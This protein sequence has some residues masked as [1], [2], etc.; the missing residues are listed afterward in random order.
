MSTATFSYGFTACTVQQ[1]VV[2]ASTRTEEKQ[3]PSPFQINASLLSS[4]DRLHTAVT[5]P[6]RRAP[7]ANMNGTASISKGCTAGS[8]VSQEHRQRWDVGTKTLESYS[9]RGA[10]NTGGSAARW[11]GS[12][13]EKVPVGVRPHVSPTANRNL[14]TPLG[15]HRSQICCGARYIPHTANK[16]GPMQRW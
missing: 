10:K 4:S 8:S 11:A 16:E 3:T 14:S 13:F 9:S 5:H 7:Y 15:Q 1:V 6:A 12:R 2:S